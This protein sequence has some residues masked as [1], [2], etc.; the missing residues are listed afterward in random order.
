MG[1]NSCELKAEGVPH[2]ATG[3]TARR[4]MEVIQVSFLPR[5]KWKGKELSKALKIL[6]KKKKSLG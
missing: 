5:L 3:D 2:G 1:M 6:K 4:G